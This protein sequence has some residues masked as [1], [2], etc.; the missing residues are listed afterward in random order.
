[1]RFRVILVVEFD[2]ESVL[3]E[4]GRDTLKL[5]GLESCPTKE[6]GMHRG[7]VAEIL[8]KILVSKGREGLLFRTRQ[9]GGHVLADSA[10]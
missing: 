4:I 8:G 10:V 7:K 6:S 2:K 3:A 1:M 9:L 5:K